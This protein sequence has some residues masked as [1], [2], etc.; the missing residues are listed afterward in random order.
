MEHTPGT[1]FIAMRTVS[2]NKTLEKKRKRE[3][4]NNKPLG[5][6]FSKHAGRKRKKTGCYCTMEP[7]ALSADSEEGLPQRASHPCYHK[8]MDCSINSWG[9]GKRESAVDATDKGFL[10]PS[11]M[12]HEE[13]RCVPVLS[14]G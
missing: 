2:K 12:P 4:G 11:Y 13:I 8:V 1:R 7:N 14:R 3:I 10:H 6:T 9:G 5:E